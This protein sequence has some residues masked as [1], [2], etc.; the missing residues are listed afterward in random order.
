[1]A[2]E[3][4]IT[5]EK[6]TFFL[7]K[8]YLERVIAAQ[9]KYAPKNEQEALFNQGIITA[10]KLLVQV[11]DEGVLICN[12]GCNHYNKQED[13]YFNCWYCHDCNEYIEFDKEE[14]Q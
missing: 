3:R 7:N 14:E 1:M 10:Y 4:G 9:E 12:E 2:Y 13:G 8:Q 6:K 11:I 5:M